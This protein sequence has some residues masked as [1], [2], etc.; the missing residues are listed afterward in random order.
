[1]A[2]ARLFSLVSTSPL[3]PWRKNYYQGRRKASDNFF[4][5]KSSGA[6]L[7]LGFSDVFG[8]TDDLS[9]LGFD[10]LDNDFLGGDRFGVI[11][12]N[13]DNAGS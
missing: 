9:I 7:F 10:G 3:W 13:V 5:M 11:N 8:L 6:D 2:I 1:M 12:G 4:L